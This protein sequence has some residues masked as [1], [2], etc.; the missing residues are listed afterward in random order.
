MSNNRS[1]FRTRKGLTALVVIA[2][3]ALA[4][5]A[6]PSGAALAAT[7]CTTS[8]PALSYTGAKPWSGSW[9]KTGAPFCADPDNHLGLDWAPTDGKGHSVY[10]VVSG[11]VTDVIIDSAD[12]TCHGTT[13][14]VHDTVDGTVYLAYG[15]LNP[16]S[17]TVSE[18][19]TVTKGERLGLAGH[20]GWCADGIHLHLSATRDWQGWN[21]SRYFNPCAF[22]KRGGVTLTAAE[23]WCPGVS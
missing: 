3:A 15:H 11:K 14:V 21:N 19:D 18:G 8:V 10:S 13:V 12:T 9:V 20:S 16:G 5:V 17:L 22:L 7:S 6:S 1:R 23:D 4:L 2:L